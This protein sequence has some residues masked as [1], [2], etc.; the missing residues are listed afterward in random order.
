M[1]VEYVHIL[2][3]HMYCTGGVVLGVTY[4]RMYVCVHLLKIAVDWNFTF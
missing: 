4:V 1:Y 3:V 2:Y